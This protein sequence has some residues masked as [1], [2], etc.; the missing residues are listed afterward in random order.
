MQGVPVGTQSVRATVPDHPAPFDDEI[1]IGD[2]QQILQVLINHQNRHILAFDLIKC[3][4]DFLANKW[5]QTFGSLIKDQKLWVGHQGAANRQ[6]LLLTAG[7]QI[8]H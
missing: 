3:H 7:Q 5:R 6:H 8:A 1:S 2:F 4:P